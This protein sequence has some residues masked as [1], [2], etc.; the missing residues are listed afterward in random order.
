MDAREL[1][2][3]LL[4]HET[5]EPEWQKFFGAYPFVLSTALPLRLSPSDIIPLG[6][7]GRS[8]P[9]FIFYPRD[10]NPIDFYG[11]IELKR[12]DQKIATIKRKNVA[13]LTSDARTAIAQTQQYIHSVPEVIRI[14]LAGGNLFLGNDRYLFV[15]MGMQS[16]EKILQPSHAP[17]REM[18]DLPGNLRILPYDSLLK[19][20]EKQNFNQLQVLIPSVT[21]HSL[22][23]GIEQLLSDLRS[24]NKFR[25]DILRKEETDIAIDM[26]L[27]RLRPREAEIIRLY[28]GLDGDR[29][30]TLQE[31][32]GFFKLSSER[33]RQIKKQGLTKLSPQHS[34]VEILQDIQSE[35]S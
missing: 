29:S 27:S 15:I 25:N 32:G 21:R 7:P 33:I 18:I 23:L 8:E 24:N 3:D 12:P 19:S 4:T 35:I 9:D 2:H 26:Y 10:T 1:F 22:F 14:P 16:K 28:Y 6:R 20:F 34:F 30:F 5:N 17:F 13:I 11:V 31:I